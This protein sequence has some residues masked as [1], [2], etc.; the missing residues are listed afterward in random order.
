M[1]AGTS[2]SA[3]KLLYLLKR[4]FLRTDIISLG[5][6][7]CL[8]FAAIRSSTNPPG[9]PLPRDATGEPVVLSTNTCPPAFI[10][11][12]AL[13][14]SS[15]GPIKSLNAEQRHDLARAIC[16]QPLLSSNPHPSTNR[17]A[18]DLRAVAIEISQRRSFQVGFYYLAHFGLQYYL[19]RLIMIELFRTGMAATCKLCS[20]RIGG[21]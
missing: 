9:V 16:D 18:A 13:W 17:I 8:Y 4:A 20:I 7:L 1:I 11:F 2:F 5:P 3:A 21:L 10:N 19:P 15:V 14:S 12:F 6:A